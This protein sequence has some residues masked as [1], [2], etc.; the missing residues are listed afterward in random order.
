MRRLFLLFAILGCGDDGSGTGSDAGVDGFVAPAGTAHLWVD[1]DGGS[2]ERSATPAEYADAAACS[3]FQAA[4]DA[5]I[6]G[7]T[8]RVRAGSYGPQS[9]GGT[10]TPSITFVGD[11]GTQVVSARPEVGL[12][13]LSLGGNVTIS[14]VNAGGDEPFVYI[15]GENSTWRDSRLLESS[16]DDTKARGS[17]LAGTP[18]PILIYTDESTPIRNAALVNVV[19]EPQHICTPGQGTCGAGD[20]YHLE[21]IRIDQNVD[22]VLIDRVTFIAGGEDNTALIFITTPSQSTPNPKN[23]T[24]Q[25]SI[26]GAAQ[27]SYAIVGGGFRACEGWTFAYNTF[28]QERSLECQDGS[29]IQWIANI[30]PK[31]PSGANCT[32]GTTWTK[33]HWQWSSNSSNCSGN[34]DVWIEGDNFS[35]NALGLDADMH[36]MAGSPVIDAA[37]ATYCTGKLGAVDRDGDPR[38]TGAACDAGADEL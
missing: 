24:I 20:V 34:T 28:A 3:S 6:G 15:G 22:G 35:T 1:L 21:S 16:D 33:N 2:C 11:A 4:Y 19:I 12:Q 14:G 29:S 10:K 31:S 5:A 30:G 17:Q 23:I 7:D 25:N 38:P 8:V 9:A 37:E 13:G 18:E 36:V 26:F 27:G 32:P